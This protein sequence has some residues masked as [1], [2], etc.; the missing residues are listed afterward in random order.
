MPFDTSASLD[1]SKPFITIIQ[2]VQKFNRELRISALE[3]F[4]ED[5]EAL[6]EIIYFADSLDTLVAD[7]VFIYG[8]LETL[9]LE[10]TGKKPSVEFICEQLINPD[11]KEIQTTPQNRPELSSIIY[12][13]TKIHALYIENTKPRNTSI[14]PVKALVGSYFISEYSSVFP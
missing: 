14:S 9:R 11:E 7:H 3:K 8:K 10:I 1:L 2:N 12:T 4:K 6:R 5:F 13:P